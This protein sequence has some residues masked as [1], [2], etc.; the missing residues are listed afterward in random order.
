MYSSLSMKEEEEAIVMEEFKSSDPTDQSDIEKGTE[1]EVIA[2]KKS[3]KF[4]DSND[5]RSEE[6][7][8]KLVAGCSLVICVLVI[9]FAA[10]KIST[11]ETA[12][13]LFQV[14]VGL[15]QISILAG[16]VKHPANS[17]I[18]GIIFILVMSSAIS[19]MEMTIVSWAAAK[20]ILISWG[21]IIAWVVAAHWKV[22]WNEEI[23]FS[24]GM[25][26]I[27]AVMWVIYLGCTIKCMVYNM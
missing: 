11:N 6:E 25:K 13:F 19:F 22:I 10:S 20:F 8:F 18:F 5:L 26:I 14:L 7:G 21:I 23:V 1:Y 24:K 16:A 9:L 3:P 27:I 2:N 12:V 15:I 17:R 4:F